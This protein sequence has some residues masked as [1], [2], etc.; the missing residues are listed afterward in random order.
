MKSC[1]WDTLVFSSR[2]VRW[3]KVFP[4]GGAGG[5][6]ID[7][8]Q[9]RW[10]IF[11]GQSFFFTESFKKKN[12]SI[13][14]SIKILLSLVRGLI[15]KHMLDSKDQS[16]E[17]LCFD[18]QINGSL[19]FLFNHKLEGGGRKWRIPIPFPSLPLT[20]PPHPH[21]PYVKNVQ[22]SYDHWK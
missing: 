3:G 21:H 19:F 16:C 7:N 6:K 18:N 12:A 2:L 22:F 8:L 1:F 9:R 4:R 17:T 10:K 5:F 15:E 14:S 11:E 13:K 20:P